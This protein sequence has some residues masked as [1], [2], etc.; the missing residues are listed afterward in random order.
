VQVG[1]L[2]LAAGEHLRLHVFIDQSVI[3]VFAN[4]RACITSRVYPARADSDGLRPFGD[5]FIGADVWQMASIW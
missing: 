2:S 1:P 3:E 5:G 4:E